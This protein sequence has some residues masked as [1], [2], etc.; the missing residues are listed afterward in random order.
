MGPGTVSAPRQDR[1]AKD[2]SV[3][4]IDI[5]SGNVIFTFEGCV[6][7]I[8]TAIDNRS[9]R[10]H[11]GLVESAVV[12]VTGPQCLLTITQTGNSRPAMFT[13]EVANQ[14]EVQA[15]LSSFWAARGA[16]QSSRSPG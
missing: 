13:F 8:F 6:L 9:S 14:A 3:S 10:F 5:V 1:L 16:W 2:G 7:E 11:A 4:S 12:E 15:M